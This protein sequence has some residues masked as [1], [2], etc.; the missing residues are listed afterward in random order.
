MKL[1]VSVHLNSSCVD[2]YAHRSICLS[3]GFMSLAANVRLHV[4]C[5]CGTKTFE[6]G[7]KTEPLHSSLITQN[8]WWK[9]QL[10][11]R[12]SIKG[13]H[14]SSYI[15]NVR[16]RETCARIICKLHGLLLLLVQHP[17]LF[18]DNTYKGKRRFLP[19]SNR[20]SHLVVLFDSVWM[21]ISL[22]L[23]DSFW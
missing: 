20:S 4:L 8:G 18:Q 10:L 23:C 3:A 7:T 11:D 17:W 22:L 5:L 15:Q 21:A 12:R 16:R 9:W 13:I 6:A 2:A 14:L 19:G 1:C